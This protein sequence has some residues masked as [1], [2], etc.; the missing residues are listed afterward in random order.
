[1]TLIVY[2]AGTDPMALLAKPEETKAAV[3]AA[4][5]EAPA[6][7]AAEPVGEEKATEQ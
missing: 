6:E 7:A 2:P 1:M 5:A 3:P 4:A